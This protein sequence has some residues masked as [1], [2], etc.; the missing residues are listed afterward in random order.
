MFTGVASLGAALLS[1][2]A[3]AF[4][5][6]PSNP[7]VQQSFRQTNPSTATV[8]YTPLSI[9]IKEY[10]NA[11][12]PIACWF[13]ADDDAISATTSQAIYP[14][15]ISIRRI[16]Q[17]LAGWDFI[18]EFASKK[19]SLEPTA[20]SV[21]SISDLP[22]GIEKP[23]VILAH[24]YLGSRFDLSHLAE[25][26]AAHGFVCLSP[27]YPESLAASYDRQDGL[28]RKVIT[29]TLLQNV[30]DTWNMNPS[31]FGIVGHSL[32]CGTAMQ[33]GDET[34]ARVLI[35]GFP[36]NRD[37]TS[38]PGKQLFLAS[39]GDGL[40]N[41]SRNPQG[42]NIVPPD[43]KMLEDDQSRVAENKKLPH[44]AAWILDGPDA[45]N[46]ISFLT[47]SV[48]N[49]MIDLLSPLLPV[50]QAASMPV[51]DFDRYQKSQDATE[52]AARVHP[53]ILRYLQ[54]EMLGV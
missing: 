2:S 36:R 18:P 25:T 4:S 13:P 35:A 1:N 43:Y 51:L 33:T 52:T 49:A 20:S 26:L 16:G 42:K 23:V 5:A 28:D 17:L 50:A 48:N 21:E 41:S 15:R 32:G 19:F 9:S 37:G 44:R 47:P 53:L 12:V 45:P 10:N 31:S 39:M 40:F 29:D 22:R 30:K 24:G 38:L 27:E 6:R 11:Q 14:H 34:W 54:Q 8:A 46:H 3:S 7:S